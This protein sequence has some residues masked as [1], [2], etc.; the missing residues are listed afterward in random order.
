MDL[1]EQDE[2][3]ID[4]THLKMFFV[5]QKL[6]KSDPIFLG[7]ELNRYM[8]IQF[9][10]TIENWYDDDEETGEEVYKTIRFPAV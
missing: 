5:L 10:Q 2:I 4:S 7:D 6:N 9:M 8:D 3:E 1:A